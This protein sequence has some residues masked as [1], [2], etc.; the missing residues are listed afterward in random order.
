MWIELDEEAL[1]EDMGVPPD[2]AGFPMMSLLVKGE[3]TRA[4]VES[5]RGL[6]D[7]SVL[8]REVAGSTA[9]TRYIG[10][11]DAS[12]LGEGGV[13][14]EV[15]VGD[16]E[17]LRQVKTVVSNDARAIELLLTFSGHGLLGGVYGPPENL[18]IEAGEQP[19]AAEEGEEEQS[20]PFVKALLF[21][22]E[23][24]G[25][26]I[27]KYPEDWLVPGALEDATI[28]FS[29]DAQALQSEDGP[30]CV[31]EDEAGVSGRWICWAILRD[32]SGVRAEMQL[33][34][35]S[36]GRIESIW[37]HDMPEGDY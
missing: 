29:G 20:N 27:E 2:L 35:N 9:A 3:L 5:A 22:V 25:G 18:V 21:V 11:A 4:L 24:E 34:I 17:L 7:V 30:E 16:D 23:W 37:I 6:K 26:T 15:W 36:D 32:S 19:R 31:T 13:L 28:D 12:R 14:L 10:R 1:A 33:D 8:G